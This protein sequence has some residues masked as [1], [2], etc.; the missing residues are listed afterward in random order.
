MGLGMRTNQKI[1]NNPSGPA[2]A[3]EVL[4]EEFP[5]QQGA[6]AR[7]RDKLDLPIRQKL[8]HGIFIYECRTVA[9]HKSMEVE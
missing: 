1:S 3:L 7:R 2:T 5:R 9:S 8:H 4:C 6:G